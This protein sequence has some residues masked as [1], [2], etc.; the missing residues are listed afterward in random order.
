[1]R[2]VYAILMAAMLVCIGCEWHFT[3]LE[4]DSERVFTI[5]RYDRIES[6]YLMTGDFSALQHM[7]TEYPQQ[8]RM[9]IED[10]LK[11]GSV[12]DPDINNKFLTFY[13]D[14]TLQSL[15]LSVGQEFADMD[16]INKELQAAFGRLQSMVP[17]LELPT[18]YTQI[19]S[20]DQSIIVG[21][22]ILGIS[23]DKYLGQDFPLYL[24]EDYGYTA[25][26]RSMMTRQYIVPDCVG[27]YLLSLYPMPQNRKLSQ[28]ERDLHIGKIQWVVNRAMNKKVFNTVFT[29]TIDYYMKSH[30][31]IT[32]EQMLK[33]NNY[34]TDGLLPK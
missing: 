26:Q 4:D 24:R 13:Q 6:L 19:G 12:N 31:Q 29:R 9:L 34:R 30:P 2:K 5:E 10:V 21:T 8:T 22:G 23:L 20:L 17:G 33:N 16:D 27:F 11:I 18:V 14:T 3:G 1:M 15:M 28:V 32:I 7:N 25:K